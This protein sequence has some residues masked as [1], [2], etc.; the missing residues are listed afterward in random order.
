MISNL[1][2]LLLVAAA[3]ISFA[4][5]QWGDFYGPCPWGGCYGPW[6]GGYGPWG[7][8][9]PFWRRPFFGPWYGYGV[10]Y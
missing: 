6:G 10:P 3:I 9:R 2:I 8:Y 4:E 5:A 1:L 7:G